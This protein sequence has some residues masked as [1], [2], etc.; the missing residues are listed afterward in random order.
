MFGWKEQRIKVH[1][2]VSCLCEVVKRYSDVD[3]RPFYFGVWDAEF[4]W[5]E[6]GLSYYS[7]TIQ[8]E[9]SMKWYERMFGTRVIQWH[10]R[11][12][13]SAANAVRLVELVENAPKHRH[14]VVQID[15]SLM[16]ERDNKFNLN[17][18]PHY[19]LVSSTEREGEWFMLDADMKWEGVVSREQVLQAFVHNPYPD[20]FYIEALAIQAPTPNTVVSYFYDGFNLHGNELV[21]KLRALVSRLAGEPEKL[22]QLAD[23]LK[24]LHV[25]VIRKYGYDYAFMYFH[26]ELQLPREHYEHWAQQIRDLVQAF[27]TMQYMA[28]KLSLTGRTELLPSLLETLDKAEA[29]E[30]GLKQ[31]LERELA[32][33]SA[34]YSNAGGLL[35]DV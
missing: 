15:M 10:D 6:A 14:V 16:P 19:L 17:P 2:V 7:D 13:D 34:R 1:C 20:G 4:A 26:D 32:L 21:S 30:R 5:T 28:V 31:E 24:H 25:I 12:Q 8:H 29:I 23:A 18:F 3:Y 33:W 35:I 22:P 9:R 27:N 11:H